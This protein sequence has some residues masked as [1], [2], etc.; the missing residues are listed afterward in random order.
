MQPWMRDS[1]RSLV[2]AMRAVDNVANLRQVFDVFF[3]VARNATLLQAISPN[4]TQGQIYLD[5]VRAR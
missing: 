5:T 4:A 2:R 3:A 1:Q